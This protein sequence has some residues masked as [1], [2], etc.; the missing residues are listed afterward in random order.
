ML[1]VYVISDLNLNLNFPS[2][3]TIH[4]GVTKVIGALCK[5]HISFLHPSPP[6][7]DYELLSEEMHEI[8]YKLLLSTCIYVRV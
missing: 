3:I 2:L 4:S 1:T 7:L 6:N 5:V 8:I